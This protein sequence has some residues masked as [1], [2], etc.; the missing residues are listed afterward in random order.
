MSRFRKIV[1]GALAALLLLGLVLAYGKQPE[2]FP[3]GS[4]SAQRLTHGALPVEARDR[5]FVDTS[6]STPAYGKF[7]G[8]P[9]RRLEGKV[10]YPAERI[11]APFPLIVYSHGLMSR[12]QEATELGPH[13]ASYGYVVV[14]VTY[15][16][17]GLSAPDG[18]EV[19]D[20]VNQ[21]A[22][23]SFLIDTLLSESAERGNRL[24]G[25]IDGERIGV[26]GLSLGGMTTE[27]AAFHPAMRDPRIDAALSVA[28]PTSMFTSAFFGADVPFLMLAGDIDAL[29][30][31][32]TNA[33]PVLQK[34]PRSQ[35]LTIHGGSHAGFANAANIFRWLPNFD[36]LVC[37]FLPG[38]VQRSIR[39]QGADWYALLGTPEQGIDDEAQLELCTVAT[40]PAS[41]NPLRQQ[42]ITGVVAQAFFQSQFAPDPQTRTRSQAYLAEVLP[43]EIRDVSYA[44]GK[45][46]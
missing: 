39:G 25:M 14:A 8:L 42:M 29:I 20:V 32:A 1:S 12:W 22:D 34:A 4:E 6:R 17:T 31:Y 33:A 24:E 36:A 41:I 43:R 19:M 16:L 46:P 44:S 35:L 30:P 18:P 26:M 27:L 28:G 10:W 15:P 9:E 7:T 21:P 45:Q 37:K 40:I 13:L 23:V 5:T 2:P 38:V 11:G 3:A